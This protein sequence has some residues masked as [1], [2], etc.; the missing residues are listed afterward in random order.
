M[1]KGELIGLKV[2][3]N[4]TRLC[5]WNCLICCVSAIHVNNKQKDEV[6]KKMVSAGKEL[7]LPDKMKIIDDLYDNGIESIDFSG[8][9]LLLRDEDIEL[10]QYAATKLPKES[11]SISVPGTGLN[12]ELINSLRDCISKIEFTLDS[13]E[14]DRDSSRPKGYVG[15]AKHAIKLC[16]KENIDVSV[17]TVVKR[18]NCSQKVLSKIY[19]FLLENNVKEWEILRYYPVGRA[20]DIYALNA[21]EDKFTLAIQYINELIQEGVINISYQHSLENKI[22]G[23]VKCNA[24]NRSIGI[25][26][27]GMVTSCAWGLGYDGSP[28]DNKFIMGYMPKQKLKDILNSVKAIEWNRNKYR[29]GIAICQ[30]EEIMANKHTLI[31]EKEGKVI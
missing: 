6:H 4:L 30:V 14:D 2:I 3:W 21:D 15:V 27:D 19:N 25:L 22:N 28:V 17:S 13:I 31:V 5:S 26:S 16:N 1:N 10:V 9:D 8:G 18:S 23:S 7:T 29:N 12:T 20:T 24:L 11:L